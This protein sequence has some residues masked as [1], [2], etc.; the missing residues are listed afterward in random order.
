MAEQPNSDPLVPSPSLWKQRIA[1]LCHHAGCC[2]PFENESCQDAAP[3]DPSE[4]CVY[5]CA[6][7]ETKRLAA[8]DAARAADAATLAA[9]ETERDA[10][11]RNQENLLK[12]NAQW[13]EAVEAAEQTARDAIQ[14]AEQAEQ[15]LERQPYGRRR[16]R[17]LSTRG[18][19]ACQSSIG[20][21][22]M[23]ILRE[24]LLRHASWCRIRLA[25]SL[26]V[27]CTCGTTARELRELNRR[28]P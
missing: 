7:H 11:K 24:L 1:L 25:Q 18:V 9:V 3:T 14:R 8:V 2:G 19:C 22:A 17:D 10:L 26:W 20:R 5:C 23:T 12:A 15:E 21:S 4:W 6:E 28:R 16:F 13:E 27:G